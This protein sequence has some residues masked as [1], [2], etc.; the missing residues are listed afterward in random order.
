M[1][2]TPQFLCKTKKN[3][4]FLIRCVLP[5]SHILLRSSMAYFVPS[6]QSLAAKGLLSLK[7]VLRTF[8][9]WIL[10]QKY[11]LSCKYRVRNA[12]WFV[13]SVKDLSAECRNAELINKGQGWW[14]ARSWWLCK[15]WWWAE[16][17]SFRES[18]KCFCT[19]FTFLFL[20]FCLKKGRQITITFKFKLGKDYLIFVTWT[21]TMSICWQPSLLRKMHIHI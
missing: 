4:T 16:E 13:G 1:C 20:F 21:K 6:A 2:K 17:R 9:S 7:F 18:P 15:G 19:V 11:R 10:R 8:G 3:H 12:A 14:W 5:W